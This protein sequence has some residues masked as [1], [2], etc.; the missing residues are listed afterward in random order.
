MPE[1]I[2]DETYK[3][4]DSC[5]Y[6]SWEEFY[7]SYLVEV[8][9]GTVYKYNKSSLGEAYKTAGTIKRIIGVLPEQ[10]RPGKDD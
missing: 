9:S 8:S 10:I 3:Y 6:L 5:K 2:I 1:D 7:T 4:A